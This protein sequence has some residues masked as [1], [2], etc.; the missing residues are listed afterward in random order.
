MPKQQSNNVWCEKTTNKNNNNN[1]N[2]VN[3][4]KFLFQFGLNHGQ[5]EMV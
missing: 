5:K 1:K 4:H 3:S 2:A